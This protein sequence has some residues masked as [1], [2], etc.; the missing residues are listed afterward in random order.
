ML[1]VRTYL[2]QDVNFRNNFLDLNGNF[3]VYRDLAPEGTE[4]PFV[5]WSVV[6]SNAMNS[7]DCPADEDDFDLQFDVYA[8]SEEERDRLSKVLRIGINTFARVQG[9]LPVIETDEGYYRESLSA[10]TIDFY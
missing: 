10:S 8:S 4:L 3:K 7:I 6:S 5:V 2:Y 1:K 9:Y